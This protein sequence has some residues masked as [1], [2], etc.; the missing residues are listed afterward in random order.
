MKILKTLSEDIA[1]DVKM[2]ETVGGAM[3]T[4]TKLEAVLDAVLN[5]PYTPYSKLE[6][7][8]SLRTRLKSTT[9]NLFESVFVDYEPPFVERLWYQFDE[10]YR[11][12]LHRVHPSASG[13]ALYHPHPWP[14]LVR[15]LT[16]GSGGYE[17]GIGYDGLRTGAPP[18]V[19]AVQ[20]NRDDGGFI[21]EM[22][23]P[24]SWHYVKVGPPSGY[25]TTPTSVLPP[26]MR[27]AVRGEGSLSI[28]VVG[29][30]F[31][32]SDLSPGYVRPTKKLGPLSSEQ[33]HNLVDD[34]DEFLYPKRAPDSDW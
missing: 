8:T 9:P 34:F 3:R 7:R 16:T 15:V 14:S 11:I 10:E 22:T 23:D 27:D 30:P 13:E 6:D 21:Y 12:F 24:H 17:H 20:K 4:L 2:G 25:G 29:K 32:E 1:F 19:A 28:M 33:Y 5:P 31:A 26:H 18:P